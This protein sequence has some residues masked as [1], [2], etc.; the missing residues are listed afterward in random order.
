MISKNIL[1]A[2]ILVTRWCPDRSIRGQSFQM[3]SKSCNASMLHWQI[4]TCINSE[5]FY[6]EYS[7][8]VTNRKTGHVFYENVNP[9]R[10]YVS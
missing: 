4:D 3:V 5:R 7:S 1:K 6:A 2:T 10:I 9:D 8:K